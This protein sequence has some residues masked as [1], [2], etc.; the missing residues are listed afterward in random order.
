[1][2]PKEAGQ[3]MMISPVVMALIAPL[4]GRMA[5]RISPQKL[6]FLGVCAVA[7]GIILATQVQA[8]TSLRLIVFVMLLHGVGFALFS[9]PNMTIIMSAVSAENS[10]M[11]SALSAKMRSL[12]MVLSMV[13]ITLLMSNTIGAH[14][15]DADPTA[16]V[17][18]MHQSLI[19]FS[20]L[21][22]MALIVLFWKL[23]RK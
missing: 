14:A 7:G 16:Y 4:A 5:D 19:L 6:T 17:A 10:S 22:L 20:S 15:I 21:A 18:M 23:C 12:G 8:D 1:M 13:V 9:S 2:T 11:A 3:L